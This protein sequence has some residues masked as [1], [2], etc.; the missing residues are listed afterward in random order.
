MDNY[1]QNI[2]NYKRIVIKIGTTSLT[3]KSGEINEQV[4]KDIS[5]TLSKLID[6]GKEIILVSSA[7]IAIGTQK[8]KLK[9]RPRDV[10][11]KQVASSV[12]QGILMQMYENN[13]SNFNQNVAQVLLTRDVFNNNVKTLNVKNTLN[14]LLDLKVIP[15]INENDAIATEELTGPS[16]NDTLA[17]LVCNVISADMLII[18]SDIEGMFTSDPNVDKNAKIIDVVKNIDENV[19][20]C[21]GKS[22]SSFGTGGMFTKVCAAKIVVDNG[23]DLAIISGKDINIIF[24]ILDGKNVGTLFVGKNKN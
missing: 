22:A 9:K 19:Y 15:I 1:R 12:G 24:D 6:M 17:A 2:K 4:I 13:F 23:S 7:A 20:N 10:I 11:G 18:L 8:L 21:A 5:K 16:E 3:H 14:K